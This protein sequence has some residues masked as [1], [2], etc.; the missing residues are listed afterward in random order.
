MTGD[1]LGARPLL[2]DAALGT[3]LTRRDADTSPP[4]WSARA[5]RSCPD[6]VVAVHA[7]NAAAG[8]DVLTA[9]TFRTHARSLAASGLTLHA[10]REESRAL[11]G[12]AVSLAREGGRRGCAGGA[13]PGREPLVAGSVAPLEDCWRVDLVPDVSALAREHAWQ[14]EALAGAGADV[15]LVE[16]IGTAREAEAA[17]RAAAAAGLPVVACLATDGAGALLSG[18]RLVDAARRLVDLPVPP[19]AVGVN[20]VPARRVAAELERLARALPDVPLAAYGNTGQALDDRDLFPSEP[21]DPDEYAAAAAGWLAL[22][23][24]LVGGCCGTSAAHTAALRRL[25][26]YDRRR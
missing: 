10:A 20:C 23:T 21:I 6:L 24:R 7:E 12:L 22:G 2:L 3:E 14:A 26:D 25:L 15:L 19:R 8:A 5:L 11:A 1:L 4:L 16:T 17:V 18:E 9:G 13:A